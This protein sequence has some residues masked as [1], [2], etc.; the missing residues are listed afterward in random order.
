LHVA[1]QCTKVLCRWPA[2]NSATRFATLVANARNP[3]LPAQNVVRN[4]AAH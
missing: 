3:A 1:A 4:T 2:A